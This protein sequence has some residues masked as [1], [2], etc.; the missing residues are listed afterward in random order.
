MK[1]IELQIKNKKSINKKFNQN[2]K[3]KFLF[4]INIIRVFFIKRNRK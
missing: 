3:Q 1:S 2:I 4:L